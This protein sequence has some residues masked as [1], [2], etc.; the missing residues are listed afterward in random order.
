MANP[1]RIAIVLGLLVAAP[2]VRAEEHGFTRSQPVVDD[3][4]PPFGS[5]GSTAAPFAVAVEDGAEPA[6]VLAPG[7]AGGE[8]RPPGEGEGEPR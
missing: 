3:G 1:I 2:A 4:R 6:P 5:E 7:E 8:Y